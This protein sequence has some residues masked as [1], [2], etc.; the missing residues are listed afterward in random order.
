MS[1]NILERKLTL[2]AKKGGLEL[3]LTFDLVDKVYPRVNV[4]MNGKDELQ[5][6]SVTRNFTMW[7]DRV[8]DFLDTAFCLAHLAVR[9]NTTEILPDILHESNYSHRAHWAM[10][11]GFVGC[12][13]LMEANVSRRTQ[14]YRILTIIAYT[15]D[16]DSNSL[17]EVTMLAQP[18]EIRRFAL[19]LYALHYEI[20]DV[21]TQLLNEAE[22]E[23]GHEIL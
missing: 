9:P 7:D 5:N 23:A 15:N 8:Y 6:F 20:K 1:V 13:L 14:G 3:E 19:E 12:H 17:A 10:A 11:E 16:G 21:A 2:P 4:V 22:L 18:D